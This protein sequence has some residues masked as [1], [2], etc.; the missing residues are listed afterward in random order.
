M[1]AYEFIGMS[2][3]V[4][5]VCRQTMVQL[6]TP[7]ELRG[8]VTSVN[9]LFIGA[10]NRLGAVESGVVASL[11]GPV[12]AV[13]SGGVGCIVVLAIVAIFM[14][15]LRNFEIGQAIEHDPPAKGGAAST[16]AAAG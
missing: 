14:P 10:S 6:A 13:V 1:A 16:P 4:S 7:D 5:V 2:D 8:R 3:Q 11:F 12:F 15:K 9:M